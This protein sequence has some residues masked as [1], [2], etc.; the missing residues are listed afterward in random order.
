MNRNRRIHLPPQRLEHGVELS[1]H[2]QEK[3]KDFSYGLHVTSNYLCF[4]AGP[5]I[6]REH[7]HLLPTSLEN[8]GSNSGLWT[9]ILDTSHHL[10]IF[11]KPVPPLPIPSL[12]SEAIT[13][14]ASYATKPGGLPRFLPPSPPSYP[15]GN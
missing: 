4:S 6:C 1:I 10:A 5:A 8:Q 12:A 3:P 15:I 9:I 13:H 7:S 14:P 2:E 11:L